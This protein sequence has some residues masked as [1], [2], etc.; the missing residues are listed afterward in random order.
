[1]S[2]RSRTA[3]TAGV[4]FLIT[5]VSA[6]AGLVLYQPVLADAGYVTGAGADGRVLFGAFSELVLIV[7]IIGCAVTLYPVV[8]RGGE[9]AALGFLSGRLL[10][11]A[12]IAVGMVS[13]LTVVTLRQDGAVAGTDDASLIAVGQ[14]LVVV[15]DWTFLVG[16]SFFLGANSL[17][18]AYLVYRLQLA[19][20]WIAV[21]GIVGGPLVFVSAL[22]VLF[23]LYSATTHAVSAVPVFAWEVSFAVYLIVNGFKSSAGTAEATAPVVDQPDALAR[24]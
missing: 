2:S 18:L 22:G 14:S 3:T 11:A 6:I 16:P 10:E 21:L 15:H 17:L 9:A 5:E 7:A 13:V 23:G 1:M 24:A 12:I 20:R 8:R 4:F 19:P